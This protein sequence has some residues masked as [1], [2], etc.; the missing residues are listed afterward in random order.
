MWPLTKICPTPLS[1]FKCPVW[2]NGD[3]WAHLLIP[4]LNNRSQNTFRSACDA[5]QLVDI[6]VGSPLTVSFTWSVTGGGAGARCRKALYPGMDEQ[7]NAWFQS[8]FTDL[9]GQTGQSLLW[10]ELPGRSV[11]ATIVCG[12]QMW[13]RGLKLPSG[14]CL[15]TQF[16]FSSDYNKHPFN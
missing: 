6:E 5:S 14:E 2:L 10:Y 8:A 4:L 3:W 15:L 16:T 9:L 1:W 7:Q 13:Q 12:L 11:F